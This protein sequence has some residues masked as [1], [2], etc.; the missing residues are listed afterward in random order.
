[1]FCMLGAH[2]REGGRC[3]QKYTNLHQRYRI[4]KGEKLLRTGGRGG[5]CNQEQPKRKEEDKLGK[6]GGG[7][8]KGDKLWIQGSC[9]QEYQ[10]KPKKE[11]KKEDRLGSDKVAAEDLQQLAISLRS[12]NPFNFQLSG[13]GEV[14]TPTAAK[15]SPEEKS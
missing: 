9:S 10:E 1:M 3:G 14:R 15:S 6:Q 7:R 12:R 8:E 11:I 5:S 2:G 13:K 4:I